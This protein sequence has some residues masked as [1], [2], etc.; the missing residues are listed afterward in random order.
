MTKWEY[1]QLA[2]DDE[3]LNGNYAVYYSAQE[4]HEELG[5]MG[6]GKNVFDMWA[7]AVTFLGNEGWEAFSISPNGNLW[8]FKRERRD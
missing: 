4:R 5:P 7:D 8:Y 1:C 6:S 2:Y 3:M